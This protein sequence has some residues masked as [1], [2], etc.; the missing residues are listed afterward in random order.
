MLL[1]HSL[2]V[3]MMGR[4]RTTNYLLRDYFNLRRGTALMSALLTCGLGQADLVLAL[5]R[6]RDQ[7]T[8]HRRVLGS[9]IE[10]LVGHPILVGPACLLN[11]RLPTTRI[12]R[13]KDERRITF[14][15][16]ENPRAPATEAYLRWCE[17]RV[18]RT[19][20]QLL[21]RGITKRDIRKSQR[22]GWI[23]IEENA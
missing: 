14:V 20:G 12:V 4:D 11:Y 23:K 13:S 19:V 15:L 21:V 9:Y 22:R 3:T 7:A 1:K 2:V 6:L 18:G 10:L 17:Y 5:L 16:G 8:T